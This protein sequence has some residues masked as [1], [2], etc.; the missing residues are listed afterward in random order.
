MKLLS[1]GEAQERL[2]IS[3]P[4]LYLWVKQGKLSPQRAGRGLRFE[5]DE[6]ERLM[7]RGTQVAA[8]IRRG[9]LSD[10]RRE[11]A[12]SVRTNGRPTLLLE[13]LG[14]PKSDF[15][16]ARVAADGLGGGIRTPAPGGTLFDE[17]LESKKRFD[18][19]FLSHEESIW[20]IHD[21]RTETSPAGGSYIA[22]ELTRPAG[23]GEGDER[24]RRLKEF[25]GTMRA[26][27]Y[28]GRVKPW[29]R[30]DLNERG[31]G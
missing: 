13:Y 15:V 22:V 31:T 14:E 4:T 26:G 20:L 28:T 29:T 1:S 7:G 6:V 30:D 2:G 25:V 21:V 17:L 9:R 16:R 27:I 5:E 24:D 11:V 3:R 12:R 10:A 18:Y 19:V 8:W 23:P